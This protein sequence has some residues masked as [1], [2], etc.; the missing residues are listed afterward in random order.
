MGPRKANQEVKSSKNPLFT[1]L[2]T[3][4]TSFTSVLTPQ[5]APCQG[6]SRYR[7]LGN[8]DRMHEQT[9]LSIF[10][11]QKAQ[12]G[13]YSPKHAIKGERNGI[14]QKGSKRAKK[15]RAPLPRLWERASGVLPLLESIMAG[16]S[17]LLLKKQNFSFSLILLILFVCFFLFL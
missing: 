1:A 4:G 9:D 14:F 12:K 8:C 10:S 3:P 11:A 7:A 2:C 13:R 17:L 16:S 6:P 15:G 5:K